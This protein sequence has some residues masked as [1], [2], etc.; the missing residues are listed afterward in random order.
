MPHD[1]AVVHQQDTNWHKVSER[2]RFLYLLPSLSGSLMRHRPA[3]NTGNP[4]VLVGI[5]VD[6]GF[7]IVGPR[8]GAGRN[9]ATSESY[10]VKSRLTPCHTP[11]EL[12]ACG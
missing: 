2:V 9:P 12:R 6:G 1:R 10:R 8:F 11:E 7:R 3:A 4:V 5:A